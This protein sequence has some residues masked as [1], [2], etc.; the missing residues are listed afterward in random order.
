M[1]RRGGATV[2]GGAGR[3]RL[4][5]ELYH[6]IRPEIRPGSAGLL[7]LIRPP[8]AFVSHKRGHYGQVVLSRGTVGVSWKVREP[9]PALP[10]PFVARTT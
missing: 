5:R 1:I 8:R 7:G 6:T 10:Q 3:G 4:R 9:Y 2:K